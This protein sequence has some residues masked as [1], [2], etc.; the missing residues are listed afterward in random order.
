MF[1]ASWNPEATYD[2][3]DRDIAFVTFYFEEPNIFEYFRQA[4]MTTVNFISQ[5]GGLMGLC[6]GFSFVSAIELFFW[7]T[8]RMGR[9]C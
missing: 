2:A 9:N 6:L 1:T 3:Y 8:Y 4:R 5:V 7:F